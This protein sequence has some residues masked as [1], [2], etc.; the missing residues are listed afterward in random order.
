MLKLN[1]SKTPIVRKKEVNKMPRQYSELWNNF[2]RDA[3]IYIMSH[4]KF[5]TAHK[6]GISINPYERFKNKDIKVVQVFKKLGNRDFAELVEHIA[7]M[8]A[9][10]KYGQFDELKNDR[11]KKEFAD[12]GHS[13]WFACS[14]AQASGCIAQA[15]KKVYALNFD[16]LELAK[17]ALTYPTSKGQEIPYDM[18]R[19][20]R[21]ALAFVGINTLQAE[22]N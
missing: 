21:N 18:T 5:P 11:Q 3:Y 4:A 14:H 10:V 17:F 19:W 15:Y 9:L 2:D 8:Y 7:Q 6:I 12:S 20:K 22:R 16:K 1:G 13:E